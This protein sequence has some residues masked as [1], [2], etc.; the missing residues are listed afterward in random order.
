[1]NFTPDRQRESLYHPLVEFGQKLLAQGEEV[2]TQGPLSLIGLMKFLT[3]PREWFSAKGLLFLGGLAAA[4]YGATLLYRHLI[5]WWR[6]AR[7][8]TD[9]RASGRLLVPFY[10]RFI[11]VMSARGYVRSAGQTPA[12]FA[13]EVAARWNRIPQLA[14]VGE[15]PALI[16]HQF[17][18][19]RFG[20]VRLNDAETAAVNSALDRLKDA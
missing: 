3:N 9:P 2:F 18:R 7:R 11:D 19:V 4:G 16:T 6:S 1:M 12:E 17:Y 8:L 10:E 15:A 5:R 20:S 14:D 13:H